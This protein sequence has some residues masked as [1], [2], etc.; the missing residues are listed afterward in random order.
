MRHHGNQPL[1]HLVLY[2][3]EHIARAN[4]WDSS[5]GGSGKVG[6]VCPSRRMSVP[7][8]RLECDQCGWTRPSR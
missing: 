8:G 7:V 4:E 3:H 1:G 2:C 5:P 6:P